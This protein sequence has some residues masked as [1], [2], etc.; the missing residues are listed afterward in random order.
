MYA[1]DKNRKYSPIGP[2]GMVVAEMRRV[3]RA[4]VSASFALMPVMSFSKRKAV[5][6]K[7]RE[8]FPPIQDNF[9]TMCKKHNVKFP[10]QLASLMPHMRLVKSPYH[11]LFYAI[12]GEALGKMGMRR[13]RG[14]RPDFEKNLGGEIKNGIYVLPENPLVAKLK[15]AKTYGIEVSNE[16]DI[17]L[18]DQQDHRNKFF[19]VAANSKITATTLEETVNFR[20]FLCRAYDRAMESVKPGNPITSYKGGDYIVSLTDVGNEAF[21]DSSFV[22]PK[23]KKRI[24]DEMSR[25]VNEEYVRNTLDNG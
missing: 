21:K 23:L 15:T 17:K 20:L 2:L 5:L 13:Q 11:N 4:Q 16:D 3:H 7:S 24:L 1:A 14:L 25:Q 9:E 18:L 8:K 12:L 10:G 19:N 22:N 6:K